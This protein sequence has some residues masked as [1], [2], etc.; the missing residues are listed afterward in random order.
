MC[1]IGIL[2]NIQVDSTPHKNDSLEVQLLKDE[3][4]KLRAELS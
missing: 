3:V 1:S 4:N 2:Q